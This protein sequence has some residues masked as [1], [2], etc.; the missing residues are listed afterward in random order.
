MRYVFV[1][2]LLAFSLSAAAK[3]KTKTVPHRTTK[4][5]QKAPRMP[6]NVNEELWKLHKNLHSL[7]SGWHT[8]YITTNNPNTPD[9]NLSLIDEKAVP[10]F[11]KYGCEVRMVTGFLQEF[12]VS[13]AT[14]TNTKHFSEK[15]VELTLTFA[16]PAPKIVVVRHN[17]NENDAKVT[18]DVPGNDFFIQSFCEGT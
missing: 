6:A 1:I 17:L 13:H 18:G 12:R 9:K 2:F 16:T 3:S 14:V 15:D 10:R 7:T 8:V 5:P 4:L 11:V